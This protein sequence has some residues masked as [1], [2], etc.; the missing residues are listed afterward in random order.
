M[1]PPARLPVMPSGWGWGGDEEQSRMAETKRNWK[2]KSKWDMASMD[3]EGELQSQQATLQGNK[4]PSQYSTLTSKPKHERCVH[5]HS[6]YKPQIY[7]NNMGA[8]FRACKLQHQTVSVA[9]QRQPESV[10][11]YSNVVRFWG[12]SE[13]S[14]VSWRL[15]SQATMTECNLP[16]LTTSTAT[17]P[18]SFFRALA[19][20]WKNCAK[21]GLESP[22]SLTDDSRGEGGWAGV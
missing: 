21:H 11:W 8:L 15:W 12:I 19:Q 16:R 18:P 9:F 22:K 2:V 4:A 10:W 1:T 17:H 3:T 6:H 14:M 7:F 13:W 5:F 20:G